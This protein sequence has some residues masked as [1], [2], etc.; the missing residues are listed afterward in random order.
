MM[1]DMGSAGSTSQQRAARWRTRSPWA[2]A[3]IQIIIVALVLCLD[4]FRVVS[5]TSRVSEDIVNRV[6]AN[7]YPL[8]RSGQDTASTVRDN[9]S[10]VLLNDQD[11]ERANPSGGY[12]IPL[13]DHGEIL[14]TILCQGPAAIFVDINFR[15][16]R[17]DGDAQL[18][19]EALGYR[20]RGSECVAGVSAQP[21]DPPIFVAYVPSDVSTCDPMGEAS[22]EDCDARRTFEPLRKAVRTV[23]MPGSADTRRYTLSDAALTRGAKAGTSAAVELY[24]HV[25]SQNPTFAPG[26]RDLAALPISGS[27]RPQ[28][29]VRWGL[30]SSQPE[31]GP[32]GGQELSRCPQRQGGAPET[33]L[34][35]QGVLHQLFDE[36]LPTLGRMPGLGE[37]GWCPYHPTLSYG[38]VSRM[39]TDASDRLRSLIEGRI[40][41]YGANITAVNDVVVSPVLGLLPGAHWHAMALDNL[42]T[43]GSGYWRDPPEWWSRT[44]EFMLSTVAILWGVLIA[45]NQKAPISWARNFGLGF[46]GYLLPMLRLTFFCAFAASEWLNWAPINWT[47][48]L[49]IVTLAQPA[50]F[51]RA[52]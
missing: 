10:V 44:L 20:R 5:G 48:L 32:H 40:I 2:G 28:L 39:S 29:A 19:A 18:L 15:W 1:I 3:V 17:T 6:L 38:T 49:A 24:R 21:G 22:Q 43:F 47:G 52:T 41:I 12:P 25:C 11:A 33:S 27:E 34:V 23:A 26:C 42:L 30:R 45:R 8:P 9:I 51:I 35:S 7:S 37:A 46:G 16:Q 36:F 31:E 4:P 13:R 14:R 50:L